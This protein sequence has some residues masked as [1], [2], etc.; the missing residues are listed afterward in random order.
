METSPEID[1]AALDRDIARAVEVSESA[2]KDD[3]ETG[4]FEYPEKAVAWGI[5]QGAFGNP[6]DNGTHIHAKAA[7]DKLKREQNPKTAEE[8][9]ALWRADVAFRIA[10][11]EE[12]QA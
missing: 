3:D 10:N 5:A 11:L 7:Y 8:M 2:A 12:A 9:G 6:A 1:D 4:A